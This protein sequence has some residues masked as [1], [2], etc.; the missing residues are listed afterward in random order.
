M[1]ILKTLRSVCD[2]YVD[3]DFKVRD[4]C[5]ITG[6]YRGSTQRDCNAKVPFNHKTPVAFYNLKIYDSYLIMQEQIKFNFNINVI[7]NLL[8][9]LMSFNINNKLI[10]IDSFQF[11]S[12]SLDS[13]VKI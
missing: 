8:K 9:K 2:V 3:C 5:H 1:R 6:K 7:S 11:L 4:H 10:S 13:L 12:P